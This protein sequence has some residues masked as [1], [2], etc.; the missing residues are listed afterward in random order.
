MIK[1]MRQAKLEGKQLFYFTVPASVPITLV[2]NAQFTPDQ[3]QQGNPFVSHRGED[4]G[5]IPD[6]RETSKTIKIMIPT[7][8]GNKLSTRK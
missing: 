7:K 5:M 6:D 4:Y 1:L 3:L 8:G 2:E